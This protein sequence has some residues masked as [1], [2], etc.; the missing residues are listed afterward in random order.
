MIIVFTQTNL[1]FVSGPV[2]EKIKKCDKYE[3]KDSRFVVFP[4]IHDA[5]LY[6]KIHVLNANSVQK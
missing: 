4:T 1:Q 6:A 3:G 5:V 2:F